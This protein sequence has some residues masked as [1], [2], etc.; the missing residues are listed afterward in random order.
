[1]RLT[2][3]SSPP[4]DT[5][6]K[7]MEAIAA[8]IQNDEMKKAQKQNDEREAVDRLLASPAIANHPAITAATAA[9]VAWR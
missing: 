1:M 3:F 8:E 7:E 9:N 6:R 5:I 4:A 2:A